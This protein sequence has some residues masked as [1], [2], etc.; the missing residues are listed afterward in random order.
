MPW[1]RLTQIITI[2]VLDHHL[3]SITLEHHYATLPVLCVPYRTGEIEWLAGE[4]IIIIMVIII[5]E[6]QRIM[7][8]MLYPT[9]S[10]VR[11]V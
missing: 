11:I 6:F 5:L 8:S 9:H 7:L 10:E 4:I 3:I 1:A 2:I